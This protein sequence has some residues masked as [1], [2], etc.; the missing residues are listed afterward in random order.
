MKPQ[1]CCC[2]ICKTSLNQY[3][4]E[5]LPCTQ[6]NKIVCKNCFGAKLKGVSWEEEDKLRAVWK[7]PSCTGTCICIRCKNKKAS[8]IL[9]GTGS[10]KLNVSTEDMKFSNN[11]IHTN[12]DGKPH[13]IEKLKPKVHKVV[14]A[15]LEEILE[16]EK[17][18]DSTLKEM[19]RMLSVLRREKEE[20][21]AEREKLE[22]MTK[23]V[24]DFHFSIILMDDEE[25]EDTLVPAFD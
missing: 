3:K 25:A 18:C 10:P 2:H 11:K 16:S 17:R 5:F 22:G 9:N 8:P 15:Q 19:E 14:L 21:C 12:G 1:T 24:E 23:D 4:R 20:I 7:C 6:C 13:Q